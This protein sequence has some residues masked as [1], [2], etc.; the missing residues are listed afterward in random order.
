MF[1]LNHCYAGNHSPPYLPR[2]RQLTCCWG[3]SDSNLVSLLCVLPPRSTAL[4]TSA[5]SILGALNGFLYVLWTQRL[6]SW[7]CGFNPQFVPLR[8]MFRVFFL[9][10]TAP[11]F[12]LWFF[13][14]STCGFAPEPRW[15]IWRICSCEGQLW[16]WC[17][18]LGH[19]V[20]GSTQGSW[21]LGQQKIQCSRG[22]WQPVLANALQ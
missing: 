19:R 9:S 2:R 10:H 3:S 20:S 6:P 12:Q 11:G 1:L 15:R 8:D 5:F 18:S 16:R 17:S 14:T 21:L 22:V 4:S 13:P 7:L